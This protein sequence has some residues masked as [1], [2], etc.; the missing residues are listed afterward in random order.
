VRHAVLKLA[1]A[2]LAALLMSA[3]ALGAKTFVYCSEGSP[4]NFT[5]DPNTSGTSF[6]AARPN[7]RDPSIFF[8]HSGL[9]MAYFNF[10]EAVIW[11]QGRISC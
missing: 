11:A 3:T 7:P 9:V 1:G 2:G 4:E 5:P 8:R 6:D 10:D